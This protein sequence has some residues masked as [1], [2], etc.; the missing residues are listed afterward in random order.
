MSRPRATD[1]PP[2]LALSTANAAATTNATASGWTRRQ[3][4]ATM[5]VA[6]TAAWT[7]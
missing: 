4:I 1:S 7:V 2:P 5:A 3:V 6:A